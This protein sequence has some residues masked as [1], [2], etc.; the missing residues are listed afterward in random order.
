MNDK[1]NGH[2]EDLTDDSLIRIEVGDRYID[3]S[4][5]EYKLLYNAIKLDIEQAQP[6]TEKKK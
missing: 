4:Y 5:K 1:I 6:K 2:P 3:M